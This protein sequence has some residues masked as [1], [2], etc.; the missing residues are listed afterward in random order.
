MEQLIDLDAVAEALA[1]RLPRWR[2]SGLTVGPLTWADGQTAI[3]QVHADRAAVRGDYSVGVSLSRGD[4]EGE[5]IVYAGGWADFT[6][7][8]GRPDEAA[9]QETPGWDAALDLSRC[10]AVFD[11]MERLFAVQP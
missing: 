11:Q 1:R 8:S 7:W 5:L 9:V 10:E 3:H 6:Y 2:S 4:E